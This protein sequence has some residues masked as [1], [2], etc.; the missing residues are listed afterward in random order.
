MDMT[1]SYIYIYTHIHKI[2]MVFTNTYV[3]EIIQKPWLVDFNCHSILLPYFWW[4][5][6]ELHQKVKK[7]LGGVSLKNKNTNSKV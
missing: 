2:C 3:H 1:V 4:T 7:T 5:V 6:G